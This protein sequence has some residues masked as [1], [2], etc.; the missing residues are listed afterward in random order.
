MYSEEEFT[1]TTSEGVLWVEE[2]KF[3]GCVV[4]EN[5]QFFIISFIFMYDILTNGKLLVL[6]GN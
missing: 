5:F 1:E 6:L 4:F 2:E 3:M